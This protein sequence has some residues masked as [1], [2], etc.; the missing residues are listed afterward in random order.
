MKAIGREESLPREIPGR[1]RLDPV[2]RIER[3]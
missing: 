2:Y 3:K 1:K